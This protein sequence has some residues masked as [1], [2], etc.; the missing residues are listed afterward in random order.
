MTSIDSSLGAPLAHA[1]RVG[2][3]E[4][5]EALKTQA[6]IARLDFQAPQ[7]RHALERLRAAI[8]GHETEIIAALADDLGKPEPEA[9]LTEVLPALQAIRYAQRH[10]ARWTR[11]RRV[12]QS[13]ASFGTRAWIRPEPR[14]CCLIISPWNYPFNLAISPLVSALAAGNTVLIKPSEQAPATS[15]LIAKLIAAAFPADQVT[16]VEGGRETALALL[17]LPFDHVFFTGSTTAGRQVMA[18]AARHLASVTLELGG[19]SPVVIGPGA[20]LE[21]AARWI[22]FGKFLN[23]GQTCIAPDHVL[24]HRDVRRAFLEALRMRIRRVYGSGHASADLASL[25][26]QKH[27][28]RLQRMLDQ[29]L[30]SGARVIDGDGPRERRMG[31]TLVEAVTPDMSLDQEEIFG[32]LLPIIEFSDLDQV[33]TRINTRE[34]PLALYIFE[35]DRRAIERL[36]ASTSSGGVGV[37]LTIMQYSHPGLPFGGVNHSGFGAS[38]GEHGFR[39]FSHERAI[40][41]NRHSPLPALFAPYSD[42]VKRLIRMTRRLLG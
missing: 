11:R 30:D 36:I 14:G 9:I 4:R 25:V 38:H 12:R 1:H 28:A 19:K 39:S 31:P 42:R 32:P 37:N 20:D 17:D 27:A 3:R 8:E 7:R 15:A 41:E 40:L 21:Q 34:K 16:V 35:R 5:F 6:I 13:L 2:V 29:A 18:A 22:V 26:S 10:L 23:A 33:I 24:V